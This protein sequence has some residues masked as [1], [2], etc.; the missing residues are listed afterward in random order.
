MPSFPTGQTLQRRNGLNAF[1]RMKES[2]SLRPRIERPRDR[3][4]LSV[5][6]RKACRKKARNEKEREREIERLKKEKKI[7]EIIIV[8]RWRLRVSLSATRKDWQNNA[9]GQSEE[10]ERS[11]SLRLSVFRDPFP[12]SLGKNA[13][14]SEDL[15]FS[16]M[17]RKEHFSVQRS[18]SQRPILTRDL[19]ELANTHWQ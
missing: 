1:Y 16:R 18:E 10:L 13:H 7:D 12:S 4:A 8:R 9:V 6:T 17:H 3:C 2:T 5:Q 19:C 11:Q 14:D 15:L